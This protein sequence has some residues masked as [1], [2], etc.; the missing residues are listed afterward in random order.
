MKIFG[1]KYV[2][3][4]ISQPSFPAEKVFA[5]GP[6]NLRKYITILLIIQFSYY[7]NAFPRGFK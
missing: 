6:C 4:T 3:H 7:I 5:F 1:K 2:N